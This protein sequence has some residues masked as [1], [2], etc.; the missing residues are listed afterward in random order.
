MKILRLTQNMHRYCQ[1]KE[2]SR[3]QNLVR[4]RIRRKQKLHVEMKRLSIDSC[5]H[6]YLRVWE[7]SEKTFWWN[8]L[9]AFVYNRI[10]GR[11]LFSIVTQHKE[12]FI[13]QHR[14]FW[15]C[16]TLILPKTNHF[17]PNFAIILLKSNQICPNLINFAPPNNCLPHL[18][19]FHLLQHW[20]CI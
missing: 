9:I 4:I 14:M 13:M 6:T 20:F 5:D 11:G 10:T 3:K 17:C 19:R 2:V 15:G 8:K 12:K 7:M 1:Q 16:K 18:L